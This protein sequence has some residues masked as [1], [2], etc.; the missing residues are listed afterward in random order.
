MYKSASSFCIAC[1]HRLSP[2]RRKLLVARRTK[3]DYS[4]AKI[5]YDKAREKFQAVLDTWNR[6]EHMQIQE[7]RQLL[8][9]ASVMTSK[10]AYGFIKQAID[11]TLRDWRLGDIQSED[12]DLNS[13]PRDAPTGVSVFEYLA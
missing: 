5:G 11:K 6:E 9:R 12:A 2:C 7:N 3:D 1:I 4:A 8:E 10:K 13:S